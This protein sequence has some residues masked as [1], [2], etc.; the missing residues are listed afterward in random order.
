ML[1]ILG[2]I[3]LSTTIFT[4]K[5]QLHHPLRLLPLYNHTCSKV[6]GD[7][8]SNPPTALYEANYGTVSAG[9]AHAIATYGY[10][11]WGA[12]AGSTCGCLS[13]TL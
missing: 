4:H 2:I 3:L 5:V 12:Y 10:L 11:C 6:T 9:A 8:M 1:V 13:A 7:F